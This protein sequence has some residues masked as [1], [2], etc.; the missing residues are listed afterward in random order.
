[1][2]ENVS[3]LVLEGNATVALVQELFIARAQCEACDSIEDIGSLHPYA[4][5]MGAVLR[6]SHCDG[7]LMR[8]VHTPWPL[9]R[10]KR[11]LPKILVVKEAHRCYG[12]PAICADREEE[13]EIAP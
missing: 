12:D 10:K 8:A 3:D 2:T 5:P 7:I 4:A 9:A 13:R 6:C 11:A 1:V